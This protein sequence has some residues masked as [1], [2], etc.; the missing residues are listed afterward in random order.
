MNE[1][2]SGCR[3]VRIGVGLVFLAGEGNEA[4][5]GLLEE[6]ESKRCLLLGLELDLEPNESVVDHSVDV[7]K[8]ET[9]RLLNNGRV[10]DRSTEI[11][12]L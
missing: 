1:V 8:A 2:V 4:L 6:K 10:G 3:L 9:S 11:S 12:A 5:E 7:E